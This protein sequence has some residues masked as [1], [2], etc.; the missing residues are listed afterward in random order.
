MKIDR[1]ETHDRFKQYQNQWD[2]IVQGCLDCISGV[3]E[4]FKG[5]FYVFAHTRTVENDE[6]SDLVLKWGYQ[7]E[8]TPNVRLIWQPRITKPKAEPNSYLFLAR[9]GSDEIQTIWILPK[10]ELWDNFEPGKMM[11]NEDIWTSILNYRFNRKRLEAPEPDGP[12]KGQEEEF[13]R[14][15]GHEAQVKKDKIVKLK[16]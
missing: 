13:R 1:L 4:A 15:V 8:K 12:T 10:Q 11:E 9:K 16:I 3:P 6:R 5:P 7:K 14:I 2:S